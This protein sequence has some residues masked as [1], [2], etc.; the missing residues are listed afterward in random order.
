MQP[1]QLVCACMSCMYNNWY[2]G[3]ELS[4]F[5]WELST[6]NIRCYVQH[7]SSEWHAI[8]RSWWFWS[9]AYWYPGSIVLAGHEPIL[10]GRSHKDLPTH[11][12][13]VLTKV[14]WCWFIQPMAWMTIWVDV[15]I[16]HEIGG[17]RIHN[18]TLYNPKVSCSWARSIIRSS[19][20]LNQM[21]VS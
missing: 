3:L 11:D 10:F 14:G 7:G 13:V 9:K 12:L 17:K 20:W 18:V 15:S 19:F 8:C 1:C 2:M 6:C 4:W 21:K 5:F 16:R